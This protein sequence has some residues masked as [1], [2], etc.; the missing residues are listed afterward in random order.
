[1]TVGQLLFLRGARQVLTLRGS[2]GVR[3]GAALDD[4]AVIEDGS[5]LIRDRV[6]EAVGSTRRLENLKEARSAIEV[7]VG[8]SI[9][10][11]A[12]VD[13]NLQ[14]NLVDEPG[15]AARRK[16]RSM[17]DFYDESLT[18]L[19]SCL[20]YGTLTA[21]VRASAGTGDL[22]ADVSVLRRL[23]A[24][25]D[26]P[27][28]MVR[29]WRIDELPHSTSPGK[30]DQV[31]ST[32]RNREF[33]HCVDVAAGTCNALKGSAVLNA[34]EPANL[35]RINLTWN[36]DP[37]LDL[38]HL[39]ARYHPGCVFCPSRL[40]AKDIAILS[41]TASVTIFSPG[42]DLLSGNSGHGL[43]KLVSA[44]GAVA[45]STGYHSRLAPAFSMQAVL[46]LAVLWQG[47]SA[48][49]A[50]TACTINAAHALGRGHLTG[51]LE[52]GKRADL[53]V[54]NVPDYREIPRRFGINHV[55]MAIREGNVVFNRTRWKVSGA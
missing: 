2:S 20:Q 39:L 53:L 26:N 44:G 43:K 45:L 34:R 54:L 37:A 27:I 30:F 14:I 15:S 46:T 6:I 8:N 40:S 23:A 4:L 35:T 28:G 32:L 7:P 3:R 12:F 49:Q 11:P 36:S 18:L 19:R 42:V 41:N 51:T 9:V 22:R 55:V 1:M 47:L 33:A 48:E 24:I 13:S 31:L 50:I 25:G 5:L 21:Q 52:A 10:M 29:A 17:G 16:R 38:S